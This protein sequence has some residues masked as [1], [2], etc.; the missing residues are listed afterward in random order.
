[1][2]V[3]LLKTELGPLFYLWLFNCQAEIEY[4]QDNCAV[5]E[6]VVSGSQRPNHAAGGV[7]H[8]K[9]NGVYMLVF[10]LD[11]TEYFVPE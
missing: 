3:Q 10:R 6:I 2:L 8:P 11:G 7:D 1:M 9:T 4:D 5:A